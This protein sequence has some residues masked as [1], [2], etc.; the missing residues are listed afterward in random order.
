[1][2]SWNF[3]LSLS[4]LP[5]IEIFGLTPNLFAFAIER[6]LYERRPW[7][8]GLRAYGQVG[9]VKGA[10]T[11]S[12]DVA[13][14]P[15][16]SPQNPFGCD[17]ESNDTATQNYGGLELSGSYR[18]ERLR[19]LTPYL[20]VAGNYLDTQFQVHA[21]T[22]GFPDRRHLAANTWTF[23]ASAGISYPLT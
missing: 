21:L 16:G 9:T 2:L 12:K 20:A 5:P 7:T 4:Y 22:F 6:P 3:A 13:K 18:I 11:C 19:G 1:G 14:F 15:P 8:V 10:F 17:K 23:S